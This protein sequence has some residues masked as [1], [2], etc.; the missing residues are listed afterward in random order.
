MEGFIVVVVAS[1]VVVALKSVASVNN[2]RNGVVCESSVVMASS[3]DGVVVN[4]GVVVVVN[5]VVAVVGI[6]VV[7]VGVDVVVVVEGVG[8]VGGSMA[9]KI[10][11]HFGA[12][13]IGLALSLIKNIRT[14]ITRNIFEIETFRFILKLLS[15]LRVFK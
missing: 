9:K 6:A 12:E 1:V 15:I 8:V 7:V 4:W 5:I 14:E 11:Q 2:W 13:N 10:H 3:N